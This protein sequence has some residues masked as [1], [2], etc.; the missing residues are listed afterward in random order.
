MNCVQIAHLIGYERVN[1]SLSNQPSLRFA[2]W[3]RRPERQM[4]TVDRSPMTLHA[5]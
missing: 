3:K 2:A 5:D 1:G 4:Q